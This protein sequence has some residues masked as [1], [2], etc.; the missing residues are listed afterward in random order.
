MATSSASPVGTSAYQLHSSLPE[1]AY[2]ASSPFC[3]PIFLRALEQQACVGHNSGWQVC[4]IE[5]T[6]AQ[7]LLPSYIKTHSYGEY[8]FDWAWADAFHRYGFHYYPKLVTMQPFT[9][10]S[11]DKHFGPPLT[12]ATLAL[13]V[14]SVKQIC[15]QQ[16]LSSW[17]CN[18]VSESLAEQMAQQGM[19]IRHGVQFQWFNCGYRDFQEYLARFTS[20]KRKMVNKERRVAQSAV[21]AIHWRY[22]NELSD[23]Q[24][25]AFYQCYQSSYLKRGHKP[26][27]SLSFFKQLCEQMG[28]SMLFVQAEQ[29]Q[30]VV[31]SALFFFDQ[32]TLYGRYWGC[33]QELEML[34]FELCFYQGIEFALAKGLTEFNP[35]TQGEHKLLRG[36]E[37]ITTYSAHYVADPAFASAIAQFCEEERAHMDS[38]QQQCLSLLPFKHHTV[39]G[40]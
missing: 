32:S 24:L 36:F 28:S 9:P 18:F 5:L 29:A 31:A 7:I 12:A 16:Q 39:L 6:Q 35:G 13:C 15:Q 1:V 17:H 37:P 25:Q 14:D 2:Q 40:A 20:R 33:I 22:G 4:H 30:Q 34:H 3:H 26:Y 19:L 11:G 8:V 23:S 10:V 21:E 38:Y 27:L